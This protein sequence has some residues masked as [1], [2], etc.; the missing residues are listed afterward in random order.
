[1]PVTPAAFANC[2]AC[3]SPFCPVVASSTSSTSQS[4]SGSSRCMIFVIFVSSFMRFCLL[5][6]RPAVSTMMTSVPLA[7]AALHESNTT[8]PG[9]PPSPC[10]M[11]STP[12]R[13]AQMASC[14]DA[15]AR[16][17]SAAASRTFLP[18]PLKYAASL[19]IVVVLP[20]PLTPTIT[21]TEGFVLRR[22]PSVPAFSISL[23]SS[24]TSAFFILSPHRPE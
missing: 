9:S 22:S 18:W 8:A 15:A 2:S 12:V 3:K 11:I 1:M 4:A 5:W 10:L 7:F 20:T 14:S 24:S 6:R 17:V 21:M 13:S 19:P 16:K 23:T